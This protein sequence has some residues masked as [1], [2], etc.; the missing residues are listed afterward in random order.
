[1]RGTEI[2]QGKS[3]LDD[4][5]ND[6]LG[7]VIDLQKPPLRSSAAG[8]GRFLNLSV[9]RTELYFRRVFEIAFVVALVLA[10]GAVFRV[11]PGWDFLVIVDLVFDAAPA[12]R[13]FSAVPFAFAGASAGYFSSAMAAARRATGTR[14]GLQL[15]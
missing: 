3:V 10:L 13:D 11:A 5:W 1:M 2:F 15:T 12:F 6:T 14:K 8:A 9:G 7:S 4:R